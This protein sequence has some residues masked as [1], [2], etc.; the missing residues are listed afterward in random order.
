MFSVIKGRTTFKNWS[1]SVYSQ[2][3]NFYKPRS[4]E[5]LQ[6][7]VRNSAKR[8][9]KVRVVGA[10]H[11]FTPLV[12]TSD[13]L[14]SLERLS[15]IETIDADMHEATVLGGTNLKVLGHAL[16]EKGFAMENLGDIN[17]QSIA[18]A[19]STGTHGT[20]VEYGNIPTQVQALTIVTANGELLEISRV[21]NA[22]FFDAARVSL[23]LF[24]VIV[25]VRLR[26]LPLYSL[27]YQSFRLSTEECFRTLDQLKR[28]N[29]NFEFYWFPHTK[30]IQAKIMNLTDET[31]QNANK[32]MKFVNEILIE[33]GFFWGI[34]EV[35][36]KIPRTS[37]AV[38]TLSAMGVPT[39]RE[40]LSGG[41]MYATSRLVKFQEMEYS[42]PQEAMENAL[43]DI[44]NVIQK[45]RL[46]VHFPVECRF[47]KGDDIWLSPSFQRD[48]AYI[49]VHMY[50]GMDFAEFFEKVEEVFRHYD[51]RG[52]W[53]K[54]HTMPFEVIEKNYPK[55][56]D[57]LELREALD[58]GQIF[59]NHYLK[60]LLQI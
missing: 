15:G 2:P 9:Q 14:I 29:R 47:V 16:A 31:D 13:V 6:R 58:P 22:R 41:E 59:V 17:A 57:F 51:G 11:S 39:G 60:D 18:G 34:S 49:A 19:I 3:K 43:K 4:I 28:D 8:G 35:S 12:A 50:K 55:L 10:G 36:R 24:G 42:I 32:M 23:G 1:E 25:K 20:G 26:V 40:I 48:S 37:K 44:Q 52:H 53:G 33:N 38:S 54:M 5:A 56:H 21:T 45:Y 27:E 7:I 30:T 46:N